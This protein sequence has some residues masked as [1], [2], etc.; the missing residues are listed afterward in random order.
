MKLIKNICAF[1]IFSVSFQ[2]H[3]FSVLTVSEDTTTRTLSYTSY[4]DYVPFG[5]E[6][7]VFREGP[8]LSGVFRQTLDDI[9]PDKKYNMI[10]KHYPSISDAIFDM[11][12]GKTNVFLGAFYSTEMFKDLDFVFPALLNNPIHL[13]MLPDKIS[14]VKRIDDLQTLKGIYVSNENFSDYMKQTFSDL[15][16]TEVEDV[17]K[18]YESLLVGDSDFILGS[19]YYHYIKLVERGL[20]GYI[21]FSSRP[22]WNMPMFFALSKNLNER[23][24][25]HEYFRQIASGE[26]FRTKLLENIKKFIEEKEAEYSGVVPPMYVRQSQDNEFTPADEATNENKE[27]N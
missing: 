18:A 9:F 21:T 13:M 3:A 20:K 1:L 4:S 2:V 23:K 24:D 27:P 7:I 11:Q 25:V 14:K 22:L 17:D 26:T 10:F 15:N 8:K 12:D 6:E 5:Y 19:Y 16:M